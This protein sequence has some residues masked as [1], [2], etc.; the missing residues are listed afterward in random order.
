MDT[1]R[2]EKLIYEALKKANENTVA[3]YPAG[4]FG[5]VSNEPITVY[6]IET[7]S[8]VVIRGVERR[9]N[10]TVRAD[11]FAATKAELNQIADAA[12]EQL[13]AIVPECTSDKPGKTAGGMWRRSQTFA[14]VYD[15]VE[16]IFFARS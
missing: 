15:P 8:A 4:I 10:L 14:C 2:V 5:G 7:T 11:H 16:M 6:E 12:R 9:V 13:C 3:Y 1:G